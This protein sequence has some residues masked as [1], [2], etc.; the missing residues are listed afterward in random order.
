MPYVS[1]DE[2]E[3]LIGRSQVYDILYKQFLKH[4]DFV[5]RYQGT[6]AS[7]NRD[8]N[9]AELKSKRDLLKEILP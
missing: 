9:F 6:F 5:K 4:D 2:Y 8:S 1:K 7:M 3:I